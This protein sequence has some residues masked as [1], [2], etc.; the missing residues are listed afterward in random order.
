MDNNVMNN[1]ELKLGE[2]IAIL[3][4]AGARVQLSEDTDEYDDA[5]LGLNVNPKEY[6]KQKAKMTPLKERIIGAYEAFIRRKEKEAEMS[7][8]KTVKYRGGGN[9]EAG[10]MEDY[11]DRWGEKF[12]HKNTM[13]LYEFY[14]IMMANY[15]TREYIYDNSK[16]DD[17]KGILTGK[18]KYYE[19]DDDDDDDY[20]DDDD[21]FSKPSSYEI[22]DQASTCK[23]TVA[24]KAYQKELLALFDSSKTGKDFLKKCDKLHDKYMDLYDKLDDKIMDMEDDDKKVPKEMKDKLKYYDLISDA[25]GDWDWGIW[26]GDM[27]LKC[28]DNMKLA[29]QMIL[30]LFKNNFT[31]KSAMEVYNKLMKK[32]EP[33]KKP[34]AKKQ[35][36]KVPPIVKVMYE[37]FMNKMKVKLMYRAV[38]VDTDWVDDQLDDMEDKWHQADKAEYLRKNKYKERMGLANVNLHAVGKSWCWDPDTSAVVGGGGD[39]YIIVGVNDK[40]N[41]DL[42][43]SALCAAE[44]SHFSNKGKDLRGEEEIRV[45]DELAVTIMDVYTG[46]GKSRVSLQRDDT[47]YRE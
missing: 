18:G 14:K 23:N 45:L 1:D 41:I 47:Y 42:T 36:G 26:P 10:L 39:E 19:D 5:D 15:D 20:D 3:E 25:Y 8:K 35:T 34:E 17:L 30:Y 6:H 27:V 46:N 32:P 31:M 38:E 43:M 22:N 7:W 21:D 24:K 13:T 9:D 33:K 29:R 16:K 37:T 2:S 11:E 12:P 28:G 4:Q 40:A 44:W